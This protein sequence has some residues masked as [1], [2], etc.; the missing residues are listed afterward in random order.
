MLAGLVKA[1]SRLAPTRNPDL[2]AKRMRLVL[3][4]MAEEGY[5]TPQQAR[6]LR[7]PRIDGRDRR[8][9]PTGTYFA[10]WALPEARKLS[11]VGYARQTIRTTPDPRLQAAP[12]RAH[13][14][15]AAC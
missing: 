5:I 6:T 1:P 9:L 3:G 7:A 4:A 14:G 10:D 13:I 11:D 12:P 8:D 15:R 2:A